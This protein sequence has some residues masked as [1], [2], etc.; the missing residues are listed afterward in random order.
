MNF[1]EATSDGQCYVG[2]FCRMEYK[3]WLLR[4]YRFHDFFMEKK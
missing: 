3:F 1:I 4:I 2:R